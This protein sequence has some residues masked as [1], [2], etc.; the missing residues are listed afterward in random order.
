MSPHFG[1]TWKEFVHT[2]VRSPLPPQLGV[3]CSG[4]RTSGRGGHRAAL[5]R[6]IRGAAAE[7]LEETSP[8]LEPG[9]QTAEPRCPPWSGAGS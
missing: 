7:L 4:T 3:T 8:K 9:V 2:D 6:W 1:S 5:R